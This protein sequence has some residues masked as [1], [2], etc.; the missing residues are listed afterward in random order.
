VDG[1]FSL[2]RRY[3]LSNVEVFKR[4]SAARKAREKEAR[5]TSD[6]AYRAIETEREAVK[7][8]EATP[9][10]TDKE[11]RPGA[12]WEWRIGFPDGKDGSPSPHMVE[13]W[14][15]PVAVLAE[16]VLDEAENRRTGGCTGRGRIPRSPRWLR[17]LRLCMM[18]ASRAVLQSLI[19]PATARWRWRGALTPVCGTCSPRASGVSVRRKGTRTGWMLLRHI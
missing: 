8:G 1:L 4:E 15:P 9:R 6:E 12:G 18:Y 19:R 14:M 3:F 16:K 10:L 17:Y 2:N 13:G 5:K 11:K 7:K